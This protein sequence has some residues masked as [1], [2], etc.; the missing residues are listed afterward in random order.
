MTTSLRLDREELEA[1]AESRSHFYETVTAV[2][3]TLP[4]ETFL[5]SL[6]AGRLES[7]LANCS[8]LDDDDINRGISEIST[9]IR[10]IDGDKETETVS[11]LAVDRTR[12][13]RFHGDNELNAP[14][15]GQ[16]SDTT[17]D[18]TNSNTILKVKSFYRWA[19][20]MPSDDCPE[21]PDYL[22]VQLDFMRMLCLREKD[23]WK[24]NEDAR[25][26]ISLEVRFIK[27]HLG[28]WVSKYCEQAEKI[29]ETGFY[30][31]FL[32]ILN[33]MLKQEQ[34]YLSEMQTEFEIE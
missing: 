33:A 6:K 20:I 24:S 16:Y 13:F 32:I 1:I 27:E 3:C 25:A 28:R 7:F 17:S 29:A 18:P 21:A 19:G 8:A 14:Y 10:N 12:L 26:T 22:S 9:Y 11:N 15:E 31:G 5:S 23:Q 34:Q 4:D 30:R 2:I